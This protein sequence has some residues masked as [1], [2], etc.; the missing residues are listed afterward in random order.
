MYELIILILFGI[1]ISSNLFASAVSPL[2]VDNRARVI[3]T[4]DG[5][6]DDRA[7]MIRFLLTS[8]EFHVEGIINSSSDFHWVGGEGWNV[9]HPVSWIKNCIDSYA[10]VYNNLRFHDKNYPAPNYLLSRWKIGNIS[11]AGEY[12]ARS[13]GARLIADILLDRSD[14]RPVWLQAWGGCNTIAAALKI[15]QEDYPDR[16]EEVAAKTRLFLIWEQDDSYQQYIRPNWEHLNVLTI[17][18]D[19]FD[20]MAYIWDKVLP[21]KVKTYFEKEWMSRYIINE[22]GALCQIY[23]NKDGAFNAE[24]DTPSFLHAIPTGL[25]NIEYPAY[26]GWGGRY[27]RIRNNVWMDPAP[28]ST[29]VYPTGK[30]TINNSWSKQM[31]HCTDSIGIAKRTHY[32]KP[33]WRWMKAVQHDFAA[34]ADWCVDD[35]VSTNH[36]PCVKIKNEVLDIEVFAGQKISLDAS[37]ST[38]PDGDN[39]LFH[40]WRY[41]EVDSYDGNLQIEE[42]KSKLRFR[43]PSDAKNGDTIH[44]IC[45]VTDEGIPSLT[46][47]KRIVMTIKDK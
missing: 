5:E 29:F 44:V 6:E 4:T 35:Y 27:V 39:L 1:S 3:V 21:E 34:R 37:G 30:W 24:G 13:E 41:E 20:C 17:I 32:F 11:A 9:F 18:S 15:I 43:I 46:R 33:I 45:E 42:K 19:Q 31:E 25:R 36:P 22:H 26:G 40:W 7:S 10:K 38:D 2:M 8:N 23:P 47:Y 14:P 16:M 28:D 12:H